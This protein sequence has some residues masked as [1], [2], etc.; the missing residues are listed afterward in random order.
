MR[1]LSEHPSQIVLSEALPH[2]LH[3]CLA[4]SGRAVT[5][6]TAFI[7]VSFTAKRGQLYKIRISKVL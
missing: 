1:I 7:L 3:T 5:R 2:I 6:S 4:C